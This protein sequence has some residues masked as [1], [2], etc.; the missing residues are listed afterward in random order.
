NDLNTEGTGVDPNKNAPKQFDGALQSAV[1]A[2]TAIPGPSLT[3]EGLSAADNTA[4]IGTTFAPSDENLA[5]GPND[6]VET[7]NELVRV[8]DKS[9]H[10]RGPAYKLSSLFAGLPGIVATT[11]DG[12]PIVLYDRMA[13]RWMIS[14]FVFASTTSPPYHQAIAVSKT[15]DPTGAYWVYD[16]I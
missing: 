13:N 15:S 4:A 16:F 14:Q 2:R 5:A 8:Y 12:D 7:T 9:G 1:P 10:P 3:F 6:I 11:D